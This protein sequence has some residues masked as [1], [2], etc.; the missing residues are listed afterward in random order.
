M[1]QYLEGSV[2]SGSDAITWQIGT[3]PDTGRHEMLFVDQGEDMIS[4]DPQQ[5]RELIRLLHGFLAGV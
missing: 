2:S 1:K 3:D 4:L 5:A